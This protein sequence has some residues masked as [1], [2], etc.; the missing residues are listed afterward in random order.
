MT[1]L[2]STTRAGGMWWLVGWGMAG[3][4]G[5]SMTGLPSGWL[6][7]GGVDDGGE[8]VAAEQEDGDE[9]P[10]RA[11]ELDAEPAD[12]DQGEPERDLHGVSP[13]RAVQ[14]WVRAAS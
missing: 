14:W 5:R 4:L 3:T 6:L 1:A 11:D 2:G 8:E 10:G 9:P 13:Q 12:D 7:D